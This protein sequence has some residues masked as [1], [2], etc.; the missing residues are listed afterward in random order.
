MSCI[1]IDPNPFEVRSIRRAFA[2]TGPRQRGRTTVPDTS[3][4]DKTLEQ[5]SHHAMPRRSSS[6]PVNQCH[7]MSETPPRQQPGE[8]PSPKVLATIVVGAHDRVAFRSFYILSAD[9]MFVGLR[10]SFRVSGDDVFDDRPVHVGQAEVAAGVAI[11]EL[12]VVEAQEVEQGG[13]QVVNVDL[14]FDGL[15]AQVVGGAVDVAAL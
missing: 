12:F 8:S 15:E 6:L 9:L 7:R 5:T 3:D 2:E 10:M 1:P 13:V 14:V 4:E 11:G